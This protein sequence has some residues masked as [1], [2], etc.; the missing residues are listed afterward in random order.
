LATQACTL[1]VLVVDDGSTDGTSDRLMHSFPNIFSDESDGKTEVPASI[2]ANLNRYSK[3]RFPTVHYTFQT[4]RGV[5][6]A[7]NRGLQAAIG[8]Y[9]KFLDSDDELISGSLAEE[10]AYARRTGVDVV[11]TGWQDRICSRGDMVPLAI[12]HVSA[13]KMDRGIDDM[14]LGKAPLISAALYKR[15]VVSKIRWDTSHR[16]A[17]EWAWVWAVCLSGVSF[18]TLDIESF[19]YNHY[20][21]ERISTNGD[22]FLK[23]TESRQLILRMAERN[24]REKRLLSKERRCA[25]AQYYYKDSKVLCDLRPSRWR[26]LW[27]H[28]KELA[29]GY[30]PYEENILARPFVKILGSYWGVRMYVLVRRWARPLFMGIFPRC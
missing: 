7:R 27:L 6:V 21:G 22:S 23:S 26:E 10:L 17:E 16:K 24:L 14:L 5:C 15:E 19:I 3:D 13:P 18:G 20:P 30:V 2:P 4:N 25:L 12:R 28:C 11:V 9:V 1:E 8:Q 29:P